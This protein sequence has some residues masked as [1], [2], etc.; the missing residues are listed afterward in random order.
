MTEQASMAAEQDGRT[1]AVEAYLEDAVRLWLGLPRSAPVQP[2]KLPRSLARLVLRAEEH[3]NSH[4]DQWG[5]WEFG[6]SENYRAGR[7]WAP[8]VD[9][10][11]AERRAELAGRIPLEPL[12]PAGHEFAV[13]LTH[14][15]DRLSRQSTPR[16]LFRKLRASFADMDRHLRMNRTRVRSMRTLSELGTAV[17]RG[18]SRVPRTSDSIERCIRLEQAKGVTGS[19]FFAVCPPARVSPYDCVYALED[20]CWFEGKRVRTRD[21]IRLVVDAGFDVGLHGSYYSALDQSAL[22]AEKAALEDVTGAAVT[23]TRQHWLHWDARATPAIH[24]RAGLRADSSLGFNRNVGF[25]AGTSMP[26]FFFDSEAGRQLDLVE[27][28]LV[29]HDVPLVEVNGLALDRALGQ[30]VVRQLLDT[31]RSVNGVGTVL[32]H[33]D[34]LVND[35]LHFLFKWTIDYGLENGAWMTSVK[36]IDEWWRERATRILG[37]PQGVREQRVGA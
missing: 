13:C 8:E 37:A 1:S 24:E 31:V 6:F 12:W 33:P 15:V 25:R 20:P 18:V 21:V 35:D 3:E 32:F 2:P 22:F 26:F 14:D 7:L 11:V 29:V 16:Q 27:V 4:R 9:R 23:T 19:Y 36:E 28:P 5:C 30:E 10:W 34:N 17:S